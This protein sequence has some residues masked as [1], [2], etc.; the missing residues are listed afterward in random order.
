MFGVGIEQGEAAFQ[1]DDELNDRSDPHSQR[2]IGIG[3][4]GGRITEPM[5]PAMA[6]RPWPI[7]VRM[8]Q[9]GVRR[10][11]FVD[12]P[13]EE[14]EQD[15]GDEP[16]DESESNKI[17]AEAFGAVEVA[18]GEDEESPRGAEANLKL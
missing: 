18:P 15:A 6:K 5:N 8:A 9:I 10:R 12:Y 17:G 7:A 11:W 16:D 1:V 13:G 2:R 14:T 4:I 3:L